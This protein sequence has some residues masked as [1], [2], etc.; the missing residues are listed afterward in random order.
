MADVGRMQKITLAKTIE[1]PDPV[2][3]ELYRRNPDLGPKMLFF[4]GGTALKALCTELIRYT[5]NSIHIITPFDSGGSSA[6][7]RK[8]F[9][10][11]AIGDVRNRLLSLAEQNLYGNPEVFTLFSHRF[12]KDASRENLMEELTRM[13]KGKH[14]LVSAIPD[15]MRKI[16]RHHLLV[17]KNSMPADFSLQKASIGNLILTAGYLE[18]RRHMDPVIF[19]FSRLVQVRGVVRPVLNADLHLVAELENGEQLVG[20]HLLTGKET[21]PIES[22]VEKVFISAK[23]DPP[24]PHKAVIR[25]KMKDLIRSAQLI[26]YPMGSFYSS[27]I[28]NL[29]P[30][31]VGKSISENPCPKV[32]IPNTGNDP[33]QYGMTLDE[34]VWT[35][36]SYLRADDPET[37]MPKDVLDFVLL[38]RSMAHYRGAL[39]IQKLDEAGIRVIQAPLVSQK[40]RP[41]L[42]ETRLVPALISLG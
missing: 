37:V 21:S 17:F 33:E 18:N 30:G 36:I 38:D 14:K 35:L 11:P 1:F 5:H 32:Y 6:V 10:M 41:L 9:R 13:I 12:P 40:S 20:Q 4:S 25:N 22:R 23:T 42:D 8:T 7:L 3:M 27:L 16:I 31:Q 34:Q 26:V 15:P 39:D 29:L 28:A 24:A 19:I 2:R